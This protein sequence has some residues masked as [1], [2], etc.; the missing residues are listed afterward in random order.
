[1]PYRPKHAYDFQAAIEEARRRRRETKKHFAVVQ[2][3][4][5]LAVMMA[6][7]KDA[8]RA[9]WTTR[10]DGREYFDGFRRNCKLTIDDI[11]VIAELRQSG[12]TEQQVAEKFEV[13]ASTIGK[14]MRGVHWGG[15]AR[16]RQQQP[17][18]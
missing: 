12:M 18:K 1:M 9:A 5:R 13:S 14:A 2:H 6:S 11:P 8:F 4:D 7:L 10:D 15:I 17:R 3:H 16:Y